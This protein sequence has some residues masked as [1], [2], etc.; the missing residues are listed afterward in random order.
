MWSCQCDHTLPNDCMAAE[1]AAA[2]LGA[3]TRDSLAALSTIPWLAVAAGPMAPIGPHAKDCCSGLDTPL[4]MRRNASAV[5]AHCPASLQDDM[6]Q[7]DFLREMVAAVPA[8]FE[9]ADWLAS[10]A[11]PAADPGPNHPGC[12]ARRPGAASG[13]CGCWN[14][15]FEAARPWL[16]IFENE[17]RIARPSPPH[18]PVIITETGWR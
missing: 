3:W 11:Y 17:S 15:P 1:L 8:A 6:R 9:H 2:E 13:G 7:T 5:A 12:A 10:H 18:L 16:T 14:A 4:A